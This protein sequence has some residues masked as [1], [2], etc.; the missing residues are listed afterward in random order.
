MPGGDHLNFGE[1]GVPQGRGRQPGS[2]P[3][4]VVGGFLEKGTQACGTRH[5]ART[6][7]TIYSVVG[8]KGGARTLCHSPEY[9]SSVTGIPPRRRAS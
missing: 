1:K 4:S 3:S 7:G 9:H 8:G 5:V 6:Y 2:V